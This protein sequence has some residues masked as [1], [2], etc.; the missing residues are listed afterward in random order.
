[1]TTLFLCL[2]MISLLF[3][4]APLFLLIGAGTIFGYLFFKVYRWFF[5]AWSVVG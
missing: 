1:M 4:A 5:T 2:L 3:V